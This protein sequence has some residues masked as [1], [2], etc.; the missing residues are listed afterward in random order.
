MIR[1]A[2]E[3]EKPLVSICIITYNHEQYITSAIDSVLMQETDFT[4]EMIIADDVSTDKTREIL[5]KYAAKYPIKLLLQKKNKGAAFNWRDLMEAPTGK[6]VAYFEGDDSWIDPFKLKK[7]FDLLENDKNIVLCYS[8]AKIL[9]T[10][11]PNSTIYFKE[12][13][14][15]PLF[16]NRYSSVEFCPM[17][18]CVV[19]FRNLLNPIPNWVDKIYA[20]DYIMVALLCKFGGIQY[21]DECLGLHVHHYKG[22]SRAIGLEKYYFNDAPLRL[23]LYEY[24]NFD[25]LILKIVLGRY[26]HAIDMLFHMRKFKMAIHLYWK[27][28]FFR[29]TF[30]SKTLLPLLLKTGI[31]IHF[32][33]FLSKNKTYIHTD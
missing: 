10:R 21:I 24:Y 22:L 5:H 18:T 31:K 1:F 7:Q 26:F 9:D 19:F 23:N 30:K 14:S 25:P 11:N 6:Y 29:Y 17:P 28:R 3:N 20:G 2:T 13:N 27:G 12:G 33:F 15:P 8:N 16:K 32:L 4:C